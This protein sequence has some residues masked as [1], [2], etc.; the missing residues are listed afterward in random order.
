MHYSNRYRDL[1]NT[2]GCHW[3]LDTVGDSMHHS[4][5]DSDRN[6]ASGRHRLSRV[7]TIIKIITLPRG[8]GGGVQKMTEIPRT[9]LFVK[10]T[11]NPEFCFLAKC[12]KK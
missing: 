9:S 10:V 5:R 8:G 6:D 12:D 2:L 11:Q 3:P 7:G 4:N 1:N